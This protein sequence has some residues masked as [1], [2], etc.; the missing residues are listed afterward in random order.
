MEKRSNPRRRVSRSIACI[1]LGRSGDDRSIAGRIRNCSSSGFCAELTEWVK[2]RTMLLIRASGVPASH[3]DAAHRPPALAE[4]RWAQSDSAGGDAR[5]ATGLK[6][7]P[8]T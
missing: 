7:L 6:Y 5:F 1:R 3:A 4:V 2:P 8:V